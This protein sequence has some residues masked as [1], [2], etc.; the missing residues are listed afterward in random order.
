MG[1]GIEFRSSLIMEEQAWQEGWQITN[2]SCYHADAGHISP[3]L[4]F[5]FLFVVF[6]F[7]GW[8]AASTNCSFECTEVCLLWFKLGHFI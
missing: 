8:D 5:L 2:T 7:F 6:R 1:D 4:N 3:L